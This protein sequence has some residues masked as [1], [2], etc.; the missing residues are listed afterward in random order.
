MN[1]SLEVDCILSLNLHQRSHRFS[2][3]AQLSY[4]QFIRFSAAARGASFYRGESPEDGLNYMSLLLIYYCNLKSYQSKNTVWRFSFNESKC[5][6]SSS[7]S[8]KSNTWQFSRIRSSCTDLG[9]TTKLC[10][11]LQRIRI[12][13]GVLLSYFFAIFIMLR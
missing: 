3:I 12:C 4:N 8:S 1:L 11:K 9:I 2:N 7:S 6:I 10:C 5:F 13:A